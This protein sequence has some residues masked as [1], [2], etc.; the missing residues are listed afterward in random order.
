MTNKQKQ[1]L[2]AYLGYYVGSIDGKFGTMSKAA[3]KA[4]QKDFGLTDSG[5]CDEQ[6]E[7]ALKHAVAYG[8]SR[9]EDAAGDFWKGIKH[10][11][12]D[13]FKCKCGEKYCD[14]FPAEMQPNVVKVADRARDHFGAACVVTSGV[15]C[16]QHNANVGGVANSRHKSGKAIDCYIKGVTAAQLLDYV[17]QQPEIRYAY[18]IDDSCVHFD[19]T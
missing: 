3:C 9:K 8:I 15:R 17:Q 2:L 5:I 11:S 10:F 4:F 18:A 16:E 19:V 6:T 12:R 1:L 7:K 13:E 14:G